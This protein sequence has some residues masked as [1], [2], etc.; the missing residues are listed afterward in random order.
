MYEGYTEQGRH[1]INIE[2]PKRPL[3]LTRQSLRCNSQRG[4]AS[5]AISEPHSLSS[6]THEA[7]VVAW[8]LP[9]IC[10]D[11]N[12]MQRR[13]QIEQDTR[14]RISAPY[15][16]YFARKYGISIKDAAR[17]INLHR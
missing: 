4:T 13:Q 12:S 8:P 1:P 11:E 17:I 2:A 5:K 3:P 10:S 6:N 9:S 15:D 16:D 14:E 7:A